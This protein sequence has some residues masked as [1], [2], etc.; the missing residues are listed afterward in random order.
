MPSEYDF[1]RIYDGMTYN[2]NKLD[3]IMSDL[4]DYLRVNPSDEMAKEAL[5]RLASFARDM[6]SLQA[7]F[8]DVYGIDDMKNAL[9]SNLDS[10][11]ESLSGLE[12]ASTKLI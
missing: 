2:Y 6:L 11:I 4:F 7:D 3:S 8:T 10:K 5:T 12:E 1:S 9:I